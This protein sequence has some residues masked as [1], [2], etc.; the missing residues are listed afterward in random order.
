MYI[1]DDLISD[2]LLW[3]FSCGWAAVGQP[4][5]TYL[6]QFC[7]DTGYSLEDLLEAMDNWWMASERE[8]KSGRSSVLAAQHDNGDDDIDIKA[9]INNSIMLFTYQTQAVY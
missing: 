4:A 7:A 1:K 2:V 3:S 9:A 6:Q 8:R 5:R